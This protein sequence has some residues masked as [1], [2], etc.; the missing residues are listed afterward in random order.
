MTKP[1]TIAVNFCQVQV[2]C[3]RQTQSKF[4][5]ESGN[6]LN[7]TLH[8]ATSLDV[9]FNRTMLVKK[10]NTGFLEYVSSTPVAT[11]QSNS[12]II[13]LNHYYLLNQF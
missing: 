8:S 2:S 9:Q 11:R 4:N 10:F 1:G 12:A 5:R 13:T 6:K 7:A 3:L